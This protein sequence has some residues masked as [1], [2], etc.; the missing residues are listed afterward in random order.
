MLNIHAQNIVKIQGIFKIRGIRASD[1]N[2][3]I[4]KT[5][6]IR[7]PPI[8]IKAFSKPEALRMVRPFAPVK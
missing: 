4:F 3:R 2:Q 6:G 5:G 1:K 7:E 8:K